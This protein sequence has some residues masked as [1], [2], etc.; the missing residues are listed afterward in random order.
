MLEGVNSSGGRFNTAFFDGVLQSLL[1]FYLH[2]PSRA[3]IEVPVAISNVRWR[4][5]LPD[6]CLVHIKQ[7]ASV[8]RR[9]RRFKLRV[10]TQQGGEIL[11][12]D[13]VETRSYRSETTTSSATRPSGVTQSE[14]GESEDLRTRVVGF[15]Q[16]LVAE[17]TRRD[18]S[19]ITDEASFESLG[20]DSFLAMR[21]I[22][23]LEKQ[24][25]PVTKSIFFEHPNVESLA[26]QLLKR[27]PEQLAKQLPSSGSAVT[28]VESAQI[29]PGPALDQNLE[30]E[31][32]L[33]VKVGNYLKQ[34]LARETRID[35]ASIGDNDSFEQY[36]IDSFLALRM[37]KSLERSIGAV[38][39][40]TFFEYATLSV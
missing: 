28:R 22:R 39:K 21:M 10:L 29:N 14:L 7:I 15:L 19:E 36:G 8:E 5:E 40:T 4:G 11:T 31:Q 16:R 23:K 12:C 35:V 6:T 34:I 24:I 13:A 30:F 9:A 37:T 33:R 17:E 26:K 2:D 25:G 32:V 27:Y 20:I 38:A 3:A 18:L 1:G